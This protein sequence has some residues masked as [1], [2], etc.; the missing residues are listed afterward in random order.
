[1]L[2]D[3][4]P[5]HFRF[6]YLNSILMLHDHEKTVVNRNEPQIRVLNGFMNRIDYRT[7]YSIFISSL[8]QD[9]NE[10]IVSFLIPRVKDF[11]IS[12][13]A[14]N[15]DQSLIWD[16][17][18]L[19]RQLEITRNI[20]TIMPVLNLIRAIKL[21]NKIPNQAIKDKV[22]QLSFCLIRINMICSSQ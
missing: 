22:S 1:M 9:A 19:N 21:Q 17:I 5:P 6:Y 7:L 10:K 2:A 16:R 3:F 15:I 13:L 12:P 4:S 20:D 11:L 18:L 8:G 14:S